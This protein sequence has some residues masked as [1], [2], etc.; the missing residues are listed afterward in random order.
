MST[1][2]KFD[3]EELHKRQEHRKKRKPFPVV[4]LADNIRSLHNVGAIFRTA[5]GANLQGIY[6]CG[7]TGKPPRN[8]IRK[9]SLG[10]EQTVPWRFEKDAVKTAQKLKKD[11]YQI[12]VLEQTTHSV[13]FGGAA[14]RF[15]LCLVIGH[16]YDGVQDDLVRMADVAVEV[17]MYGHKLSLNVSVAFGIVVYEL[18]DCYIKTKS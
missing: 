6:L 4:V 10:A 16:E 1:I 5:D 2:K 3:F 18:I 12:V 14:Y 15:P 11:G 13:D 17:P 8:E 7:I 9:T